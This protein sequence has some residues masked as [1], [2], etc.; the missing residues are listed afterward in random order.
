MKK[1]AGFCWSKV[2]F[3]KKSVRNKIIATK[4]RNTYRNYTY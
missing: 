3:F 1:T 4:F 2:T